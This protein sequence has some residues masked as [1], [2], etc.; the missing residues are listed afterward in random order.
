MRLSDISFGIAMVQ[1]K[2][3]GHL[4]NNEVVETGAES[5]WRFITPH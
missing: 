4:F 2:E 5:A 1:V 3:L